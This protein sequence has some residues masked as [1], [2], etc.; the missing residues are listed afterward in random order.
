MSA[1]QQVATAFA[2]RLDQALTRRGFP[3]ERGRAARVEREIGV[4]HVAVK[5]WLDGA[6][7]PDQK[8]MIMLAIWLRVSFDWLATGQGRMDVMTLQDKEIALIDQFRKLDQRGQQLIMTVA[9]QQVVYA[10]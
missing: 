1:S 3:A 7:L 9:E 10:T 5:K 2:E 8:H 4:S 6:G